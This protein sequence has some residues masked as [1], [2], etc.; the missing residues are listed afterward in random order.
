MRS[1]LFILSIHTVVH[2][3]ASSRLQGTAGR[4]KD[5][6]RLQLLA[7]CGCDVGNIASSPLKQHLFGA[8]PIALRIG[9]EFPAQQLSTGTALASTKIIFSHCSGNSTAPWCPALR[10]PR[11]CRSRASLPSDD[12]S[13]A[14]DQV[15][16]HALSRTT[17]ACHRLI[18]M[19]D[20]TSW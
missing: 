1:A 8:D 6:V 3:V 18:T 4:D 16:V 5:V 9:T 2:S 13:L 15:D 10:V 11:N 17:S 19:L 12:Q 7:V 14:V 20:I